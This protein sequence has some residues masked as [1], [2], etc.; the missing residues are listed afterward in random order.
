M[1]YCLAL[2][3]L[4]FPIQVGQSQF[5]ENK[6]KLENFVFNPKKCQTVIAGSSL[7][8]HLRNDYFDGSFCNLGFAGSSALS[9]LEV[10]RLRNEKSVSLVL[11]E[12][13]VLRPL[14]TDLTKLAHGEHYWLSKI[15]PFM[16]NR[17][18]PI[19]VGINYLISKFPMNPPRSTPEQ[20]KIFLEAQQRDHAVVDDAYRKY[21]ESN[22]QTLKNQV[23]D[24][25]AQGKLVQLIELPEDPTIL[26]SA[27]HQYIKSSF[28]QEFP[29]KTIW[30]DPTEYE[31]NDGLHLTAQSA[32]KFA[33]FLKSKLQ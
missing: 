7:S 22:L 5:Q 10:A 23:A 28:Q 8:Y 1:L 3:A 14:E 15:F 21:F 2:W 18:Q 16:Q 31:T 19:T 26:T 6:V 29:D 33:Q 24:L 25:E 17:F 11:V 32:Q 27:K 13:N 30:S 12:I 9:A 20:F 4:P